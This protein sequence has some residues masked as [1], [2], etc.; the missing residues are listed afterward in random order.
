[1]GTNVGPV[2]SHR[3]NGW[4]LVPAVWAVRRLTMWGD[5]RL[6]PITVRLILLSS[7]SMISCTCADVGPCRRNTAVTP[8]PANA[9]EQIRDTPGSQ[10]Q[11]REAEEAHQKSNKKNPPSIT[12][13]PRLGVCCAINVCDSFLIQIL[14]PSHPM[15]SEVLWKVIKVTRVG[16]WSDSIR[17]LMRRDTGRGCAFARMFSAFA[18][19]I[20][21]VENTRAHR[22]GQPQVFKGVLT[23][24]Q[25]YWH[26]DLRL[27][28]SRTSRN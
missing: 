25:S 11:S 27:S 4:D 17:V 5:C 21:G 1:M 28:D 16:S 22:R 6:I 20:R 3:W 14:K 12:Q 18:S 8:S 13:N 23:G 10:A 9:A 15:I 24:A 2:L 7:L 26:P 19:C